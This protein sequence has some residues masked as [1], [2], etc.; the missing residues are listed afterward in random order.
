MK[1]VRCIPFPC[2]PIFSMILVIY[3]KEK[4]Q[5]KVTN[6]SSFTKKETL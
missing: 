2:Q 4:K 1:L 3:K 5:K 6:A